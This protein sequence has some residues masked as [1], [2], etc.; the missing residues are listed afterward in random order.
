MTEQFRNGHWH[1]D[2]RV[3]VGHLVTTITVAIAVVAW[4]FQIQG[5]IAIN[6]LK[7]GNNE[8]AIMNIRA[9][10]SVQY[11]EIIRQIERFDTKVSEQLR[12]LHDKLDEKLDK[13]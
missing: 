12:H 9:D 11:S 4:S 8:K 6:E 3:S 13:G 5:R 7:I 10:Q 2:K 1:L